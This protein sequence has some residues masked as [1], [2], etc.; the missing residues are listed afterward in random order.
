MCWLL[1]TLRDRL[2]EVGCVGMCVNF[3]RFV[4]DLSLTVATL[5]WIGWMMFGVAIILA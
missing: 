1:V 4:E 2:L 5:G 3:D